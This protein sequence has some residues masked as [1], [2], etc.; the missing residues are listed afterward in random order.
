MNEITSVRAREI[1]DCRGIPTLEVEVTVEGWAKGR[2]AVP[3]G[4]SRGSHEAFELRDGDTRFRGLGVRKAVEN[5]N[6]IIAPAILGMDA[7]SQREIDRTLLELDGTENKSKLGAN[8]ILG[9]SVAVAKSASSFLDIPFFKYMN[10]Y[11][12]I[13]PLPQFNLINGGK[14]AS[15]DLDFQEFIIMPEGAESFSESLRIASEVNFILRD[16][17]LEKYGKSALNVGDEGGFAPPISDVREALDVLSEAVKKSGYEDEIVYA[18]DV[19]STHFYDRNEGIYTFQGLKLSREEMIEFYDS[20][21]SD[22]PIVSME[23]P[24]YEDDFEGYAELTKSLDIQIV[25]DDLFVTNP[26]RL[27]KGIE[28]GAANAV[29][30]KMNQIGTLTEAWDVAQIAMRNGY[31]VV[32]SERSGET[33]DETIADLSVSL[34]CGQIKTGAPVRGERTSKYN[35]LLRIEEELGENGMFAGKKWRK[36][37]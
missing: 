22:Y 2:F 35:Q 26:K 10:Q 34:N 16:I 9:V 5:V 4:L 13:L 15:N 32:V 6:K 1:I 14:H 36:L 19:A 37:Y 28:M 21:I 20:L 30:W 23:D 33:E 17:L 12:Q 29:L 31:N 3:S 18:L 27:K 25:G 7:L 24:L 8:A 11:A